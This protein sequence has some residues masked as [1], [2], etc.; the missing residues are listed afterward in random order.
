MFGMQRKLGGAN[1]PGGGGLRFPEYPP[2]MAERR[3]DSEV[4]KRWDLK[5]LTNKK[6][7]GPGSERSFGV[8]SLEQTKLHFTGRRSIQQTWEN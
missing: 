8:L 5:L 2:H 6:N 7:T 3:R 1:F 4:V